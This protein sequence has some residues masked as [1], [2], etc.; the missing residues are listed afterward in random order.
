[1]RRVGILKIVVGMLLPNWLLP[2]SAK[3]N[4]VQS[5]NASR[6]VPWKKL[7]LTRNTTENT[8][9]DREKYVR[10]CYHIISSC[11]SRQAVEIQKEILT[12]IAQVRQ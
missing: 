3:S 6:I 1:M 8:A 12:K 11:G 5:S 4:F 9:S 2:K 10:G 7:L